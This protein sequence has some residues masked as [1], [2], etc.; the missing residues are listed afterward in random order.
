VL[1]AEV[2]GTPVAA[3]SLVDGHVVADPF[4]RT[5]DVVELLRLR[6]AQLDGHGSLPAAARRR[7]RVRLPVLSRVR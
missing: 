6:A 3:I 7:G 4:E 5:A 2:D 1:V